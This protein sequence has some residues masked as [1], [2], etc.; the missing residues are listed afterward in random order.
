MSDALPV[1][2]QRPSPARPIVGIDQNHRGEPS[3]PCIQRVCSRFY[4]ITLEAM[5]CES[6]VKELV[7]PRQVAQYI[8][9]ETGGPGRSLP[10]IG[11]KFNRDHATV[12]FSH[13]KVTRLVKDDLVIR[14]EVAA[15]MEQVMACCT[16]PA[17]AEAKRD[18]SAA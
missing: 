13:R 9:R 18:N 4:G 5:L 8:A 7:W 1:A 15:V 2:A 3:I 11:L 16:G 6:R 17:A 14:L 10:Q 12:I